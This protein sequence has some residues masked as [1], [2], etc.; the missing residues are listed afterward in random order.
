MTA[1]ECDVDDEFCV[2][3]NNTVYD[4]VLP[5]QTQE[6]PIIVMKKRRR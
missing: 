5:N 1:S 4:E 3:T 2:D 6:S